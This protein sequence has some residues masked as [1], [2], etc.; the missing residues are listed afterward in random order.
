MTAVTASEF[1][2]I[3]EYLAVLRREKW[4]ALAVATV[5]AAVAAT[6]A[7]IWPPTYRSTA[8]ILIEEADIPAGLV[9]STVSAFASE[10]I[11]AIQQRIIT[12]ANLANIIN[13]YNLYA[14]EQKT[15][16]LTRIVEQMRSSIQ[17]SLV[18]TDTVPKGG[19]D[20]RAAIAFT[21]SFD[22]DSPRTVQ[23]VTNELASLFLSESQR[24]RD[25]RASGT[26]SFLEAESR[27]LHADVQ[28]LEA[29]IGEFRTEHTGYLPEDRTLN[30]QLLDRTENQLLD[31]SRQ[32]QTLRERQGIVR[33]QLAGTPQ[34]LPLPADRAMLSPA[35]QLASL[36]V[37]RAAMSARYG[38][39][40]PDV[41]ALDRQIAAFSASGVASSPDSTAL[42]LRIQTL[43]AE[44]QTAR[45]RYGAKHPDALKLERE[46]AAARVQLGAV[47]AA[48]AL[49][50]GA[51]N[52]DYLQLQAEFAGI[53]G[54]IRAI[55][56]QQQLVEQK[57]EKLE[58]RVLTGPT[59]ER[60][61]VAL[62]REYDTALAKYLDV[63]SKAAEAEL[64][65]S[66]ET[67]RMGQT[68]TLIEPPIEPTAPIKPNRRAILAIGL[69]AAIVGGI[70]TG[71]LHD[72]ADERV[73]GWRQ[74][75]AISGQTPF[76]IVP[77]IRTDEDRRRARRAALL[78]SL[79]VLS[80]LA[81]SSLFYVNSFV[82]PL[83]ALWADVAEHFNL[84]TDT[85]G[86][87]AGR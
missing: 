58:E 32:M 39:K 44:L 46:L 4:R 69:L 72:A 59:V 25:Q 83:D 11:E 78:Q 17:L 62:K 33:T 54:E 79:G 30:T 57:R 75:A 81:A 77:F 87:P 64:T 38:A 29:K 10:R 22:G 56:D 36:Q 74:L 6:L 2:R 48:P 27:R 86:L 19:R 20:T 43:Q 7:M 51:T 34:Y 26:T 18:S 80:L 8:T 60:D 23:E 37:R 66:L 82:M 41:V 49:Q 76:A 52:P 73:H 12:T 3:G 68:L 14:E 35:E 45:Q 70:I 40:H 50:P 28:A 65:Q 61:Y 53:N 9:P 21:L 55:L 24:D 84:W 47:P 71:V 67:Q 15:A 31:L 13:K 16:P 63:R 5:I 85:A 42:T 1:V